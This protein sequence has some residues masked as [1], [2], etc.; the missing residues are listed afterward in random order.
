MTTGRRSIVSTPP[1][2]TG[3]AATPG[4]IAGKV[5]LSTPQVERVWLYKVQQLKRPNRTPTVLLGHLTAGL[6]WPGQG[7]AR[8]LMF[9]ALTAV[10]RLSEQAGCF[11]VLIQPLD[12]DV[13]ALCAAFGFED[14]S[15]DPARSMAIR[16][17]DP[18]RI[19]FGA[20]DCAGISWRTGSDAA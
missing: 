14:L 16:I 3:P 11:C 12:D 19:G 9:H 13:R 4:G 17:A 15:F 2:S 6:R 5:G 7:L 1:Q 18:V 10:V 20:R 8:S